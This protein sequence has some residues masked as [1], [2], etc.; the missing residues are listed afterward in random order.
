[1]GTCQGDF[2]KGA[3][4]VL[5]HFKAL[6]FKASHLSFYL[7]LFI[8]NDPHIISPLSIISSTYEHFRPNFVQ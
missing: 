7:F 4:F 2:S 5:A 6:R 8:A 3:L 1:M